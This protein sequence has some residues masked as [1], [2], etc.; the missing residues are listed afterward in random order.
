MYCSGQTQNQPTSTPPTSSCGYCTN[1]FCY[2]PKNEV[3][4]KYFFDFLHLGT[5]ESTWQVQAQQDNIRYPLP[6]TDIESSMDYRYS[7]ARRVHVPMKGVDSNTSSRSCRKKQ[8]VSVSIGTLCRFV[9]EQSTG[10]LYSSNIGSGG[11]ASCATYITYGF[12][13]GT[14]SDEVQ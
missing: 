14:L 7:A 6:W 9:T 1:K 13:D 2:P 3:R 12:C 8:I 5:A 11:V 4:R 10:L